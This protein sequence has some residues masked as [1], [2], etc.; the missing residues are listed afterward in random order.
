M[1]ISPVNVKCPQSIRHVQP[2]CEFTAND[3]R[4]N[5]Q[6]A[7]FYDG[8]P[9]RADMEDLL[10]CRCTLLNISA[11]MEMD[12]AMVVNTSTPHHRFRPMTLKDKYDLC[13]YVPTEAELV[14]GNNQFDNQVA[15]FDFT[16]LSSVL[17]MY[18]QTKKMLDKIRFVDGDKKLWQHSP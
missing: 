10:H 4:E 7:I 15:R 13:E 14:Q 11:G 2:I 12:V 1:L 17:L 8:S 6:A 9:C 16:L 3:T 18:N 5:M